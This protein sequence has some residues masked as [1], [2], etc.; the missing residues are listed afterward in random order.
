MDQINARLSQ[1]SGSAQRAWM[2]PWFPDGRPRG[3]ARRP[4]Q[5]VDAAHPVRDPSALGLDIGL[6]NQSAVGPNPNPNTPQRPPQTPID[7]VLPS[8]APSD[9]TPQIISISST[10]RPSLDWQQPRDLLDLDGMEAAIIVQ[11][12]FLSEC[13]NQRTMPMHQTATSTA[14]STMPLAQAV[15]GI[16]STLSSAQTVMLSA[17]PAMSPTHIALLSTPAARSLAQ[18]SMSVSHS[19]IPSAHTATNLSEKRPAESEIASQP[20]RRATDLGHWTPAQSASPKAPS[21]DSPMANNKFNWPALIHLLDVRR[22][23]ARMQGHENHIL[24]TRLCLLQEACEL[25]DMAY[26]AIHQVYCV[27]DVMKNRTPASP[28]VA[29]M[30]ILSQLLLKNDT[31]D[32]ES[33]EWF[34]TFPSSFP[35]SSEA[36]YREYKSAH[37]CLKH[38]DQYWGPFQDHCVARK[39]PPLD[40]NI[41][42]RLH[43][44]SPILQRIMYR[45]ICRTIWP[46]SPEDNC[47][48]RC[49]DL[50]TRYQTE[51][52]RLRLALGI[53]D[54]DRTRA[55]ESNYQAQ[56]HEASE[57]L[58][59]HQKHSTR[60][61]RPRQASS[62]IAAVSRTP[63]TLSA[64]TAVPSNASKASGPIPMNFRHVFSTSGQQLWNENE[65]ARTGN[66]HSS[67]LPTVRSQ[68][69]PTQ[70]SGVT[71]S[72]ENTVSVP[73]RGPGRPRLRTTPLASSRPAAQSQRPSILPSI[74]QPRGRFITQ[75]I[76]LQQQQQRQQQQPQ[77]HTR[78]GSLPQSQAIPVSLFRSI[79]YSG[80]PLHP[81]KSTLHQAHLE[82][83]PIN[84][85]F[86]KE[87][88]DSTSFKHFHYL[89]SFA[90]PPTFILPKD[91]NRRLSFLISTS[92]F[93]RLAKPSKVHDA[94]QPSLRPG[95]QTYRLR[96]VKVPN[97]SETH[98]DRTGSLW[99]TLETYWPEFIVIMLNDR[100]LEIRRKEVHGKDYYVEISDFIREGENK[101]YI[102]LLRPLG[103]LA[104]DSHTYAFAIEVLEIKSIDTARQELGHLPE[105]LTCDAITSRLKSSDPDVEVLSGEPMR[106]PLIDPISLKLIA[107]PVRGAMCKHFECFDLESFLSTRFDSMSPQCAKPEAFKCPICQGDARPMVLLHDDWQMNVLSQYTDTERERAATCIVVDDMGEWKFD[108]DKHDSGGKGAAKI[109][110]EEGDKQDKSQE[111]IVLE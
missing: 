30:Q 7:D 76:P 80:T 44:S 92:S 42:A 63:A 68:A 19:M 97:S 90:L 107:S 95:S 15:P 23:S 6:A 111:V 57:Q 70:A 93:I 65:Q 105:A 84:V 69:Q 101:L 17:Q 88:A 109:K 26:L 85:F 2:V 13:R 104:H 106:I 3:M 50:F 110:S 71:T 34:S 99:S 82:E 31:F 100:N 45:C 21:M 38:L 86:E 25:E 41:I 46:T 8:P 29:G 73:R 9:D 79:D 66:Q 4:S 103:N 94:T 24:D 40:I 43:V 39:S 108:V 22:T 87:G 64:A 77:Q 89:D 56:M 61:R 16:P 60:Q 58:R 11:H 55:L 35:I 98:F 12:P 1:C 52:R 91:R 10:R 5:P 96:C 78:V 53:T 37:T 62:N 32:K 75:S 47:L 72:S 28:V 14:Q 27:N 81:V 33:L 102:S 83:S 67:S 48:T 74:S 59:Q 54:A 51:N 36:Y 49:F 20:K 18:T